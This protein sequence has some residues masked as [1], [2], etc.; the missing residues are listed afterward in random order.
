M[1]D[2]VAA[3]VLPS[4][5]FGIC[6]LLPCLR[7]VNV[8]QRSSSSGVRETMFPSSSRYGRGG[9]FI[10]L[11]PYVTDPEIMPNLS[12]ILEKYPKIK[13]AITQDDGG[14]YGLPSA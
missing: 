10:D 8:F 11:A 4:L 12:A 7:E 5:P 9:T 13:A 6:I 3:A 2:T 1:P 14:I